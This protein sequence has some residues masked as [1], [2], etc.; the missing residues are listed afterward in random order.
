MNRK[1]LIRLRA[2][3]EM[4]SGTFNLLER[5]TLKPAFNL[6]PAPAPVAAPIY[7]RSRTGNGTKPVLSTGTGTKLVLSTGSGTSTGT[8]TAQYW[9]QT[10]LYN[11][12][13]Q[14]HRNIKFSPAPVPAPCTGTGTTKNRKRHRHLG[15]WTL[16]V[17]QIMV[18]VF[19]LQGV[20]IKFQQ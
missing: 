1:E 2:A 6:A 17:H 5:N 16:Q 15:V 14:Q 8:D 4:R 13:R 11:Q 20:K 19:K 7:K 9:Q 10:H 3:Y 12:H 18:T